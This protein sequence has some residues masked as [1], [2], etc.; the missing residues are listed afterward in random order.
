[1][2]TIPLNVPIRVPLRVNVQMIKSKRRE[3][4]NRF[5][6]YQLPDS[7]EAADL[8]DERTKTVANS[9]SGKESGKDFEVQIDEE[10]QREDERPSELDRGQ[11]VFEPDQQSADSRGELPAD[12][13]EESFVKDIDLTDRDR[14][15]Q[16]AST[17]EESRQQQRRRSMRQGGQW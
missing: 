17:R 9:W 15:T 11:V 7:H 5:A 13:V 14:E 10:R 6:D 8:D 3:Q 4:T 2:L 12:E 16:T 1:H